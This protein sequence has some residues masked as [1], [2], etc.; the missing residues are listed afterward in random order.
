[1]QP[2][3]YI[4]GPLQA[5]DDLDV[6]RT[7]YERLA[8]ICERCGFAA[9]LPHNRTDP[10]RHAASPSAEVFRHDLEALEAADV[11]VAHIGA[12]SSGVGAELGFA[13]KNQQPIIAVYRSTERPSRFI[14]GMLQAAPRA[15]IICFTADEGLEEDLKSVLER[16]ATPLAGS[17]SVNIERSTT[18]GP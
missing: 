10:Q 18:Q 14:E 4:S 5:A 15:S 2:V 12:P 9:Y 11:V 3:V 7:F 13:F 1:M 6:A 16:V 8:R 17:T